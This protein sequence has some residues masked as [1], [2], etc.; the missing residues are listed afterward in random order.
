LVRF[1]GLV[2]VLA[3]AGAAAEPDARK[4][5]KQAIQAERRGDTVRAYLLYAQAAAADRTNTKYWAKAHALRPL[6]EA[7]SAGHLETPELDTIQPQDPAHPG[8]DSTVGAFTEEDLRDLERMKAPPRLQPVPGERDYHLRGDAKSL[9][10][11]VAQKLGYVVVFDK[12]YNPPAKAIRFDLD[13]AGYRE[14]LHALESAT[15]SFIVPISERAMLVAQ[16]T[17]QKRTE[18][19][20]NEAV[21]IPIPDRSS[22]QEAQE[23]AMMIQQSLE[24]RRIILDPQ[25]RQ[26]F[27]RDRVS[28][29]ETARAIL[30]QL[31]HGKPQVEVEVEFLATAASSS[32]SLGMDLPT[33]FPLVDFGRVLNSKP[34]VPAGF[35]RFLVFGG[36]KTFLGMGVTD[37]QLFATASRASATSLLRSTVVA[38]D[39]QAA[40][41][42]V[43]DKY[44]IVTGGYFGYGGGLGPGGPGTPGGTTRAVISTTSYPDQYTAAVSTT[45]IL[46]LVINGVEYPIVLPAGSNNLIGL[47]TMINSVQNSV[48]A[49]TIQRG[50]NNR[51]L[52]LALIANSLG[53]TSISLID[54]P[55]GAAIEL[56]KAPDVVSAISN[57]YANATTARVS[58]TGELSLAVGDQKYPL[59][60]TSDTNDL[61][62]LRDAINAA[63]AN[64]KAAVLPI[65]DGTVYLQVVA[66]ASGS[67]SIQIYD[68]PS[69][70]NTPLL[71]STTEV[72]YTGSS[73]GQTVAATP[74][75]AGGL[76]SL[77]QV[78]APPP[79]F[80]FEDLGL[81]L[82]ITPWVHGADEVSL[83]VE[84][85]FKVLGSGS[86]NGVPVI[87]TRK[88]QGK[89]RLRTTEWAVVAGMMSD[90][91]SKSANGIAGLMSIPGLG[92]LFRHNVN[93]RDETNVLLVLKP[94]IVRLAPSEY[95]TYPIWVGSETRPLTPL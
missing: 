33:Q 54:D 17:Q 43:G 83:D 59:T 3:A 38:S 46:K 50:T 42:H 22:L 79:S 10:E 25:K 89:V 44:P 48:Y 9:F 51:P 57:S 40:S 55:T 7:Q 14:V 11:Q 20:A 88:F 5:E 90:Q 74:S 29:V 63:K 21:A 86:F 31:A 36:G 65:G 12:D 91:T 1:I 19:E 23:L 4:L 39:G 34:W 13:G 69:G 30:N 58:T 75:S 16:D 41:L 67:G 24:I 60:L 85:E 81:V 93:S 32:L 76:G 80:N 68:D 53:V 28:K 73:L 27:V 45:G 87:S 95:A 35:T 72:N 66:E 47:Q 26:I 78:Y 37:A 84:A 6:A 62:G 71:T 94:R 2:T 92:Q 8:I 52:S 56:T 15:S 64:V 82:K 70:K 49:T 77:G 18:L 61:N